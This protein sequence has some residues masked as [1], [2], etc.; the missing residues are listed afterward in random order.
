MLWKERS[1]IKAVQTNNLRG[2]ISIRIRELCGVKK[3]LDER[4]G[5]GMLM[6]WS[7]GEDREG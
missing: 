5:E 7:C 2:L 6:V 1:R 3:G 4:T